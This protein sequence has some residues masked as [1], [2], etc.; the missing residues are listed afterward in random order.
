[1]R[2]ARFSRQQH[3]SSDSRLHLLVKAFALSAPTPVRKTRG[4]SKILLSDSAA[5]PTRLSRV[6]PT[7]ALVSADFLTI[8]WTHAAA[9]AAVQSF[10]RAS[11]HAHAGQTPLRACDDVPPPA[12][13]AMLPLLRLQ[14]PTIADAH[15]TLVTPPVTQRGNDSDLGLRPLTSLSAA[16]LAAFLPSILIWGKSGG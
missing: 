4:T 1:M 11:W 14:C 3:G 12:F 9:A 13:F 10:K 16:K 2:V 5:N 7:V 8:Q 15:S 6:A